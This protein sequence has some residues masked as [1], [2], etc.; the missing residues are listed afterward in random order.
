[1]KN[2]KRGDFVFLNMGRFYLEFQKRRAFYIVSDQS[3]T[4]ILK[5]ISAQAQSGDMLDGVE[6]AIEKVDLIILNFK[7]S[8]T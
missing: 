3:S 6:R 7:G 5:L 8:P 4:M 1:M 2:Q